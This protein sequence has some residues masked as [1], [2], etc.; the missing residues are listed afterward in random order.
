MSTYM[1]SATN[2][3]KPATTNWSRWLSATVQLISSIA[4]NLISHYICRY[5][6]KQSICCKRP[7]TIRW[8]INFRPKTNRWLKVFPL[9]WRIPA[10]LVKWF[11]II[12]TC[13]IWYCKGRGLASPMANGNPFWIGVCNL[14][15]TSMDGSSMTVHR[16]CWRCSN[17]KSIPRNGHR[18]TWIRIESQRSNRGR[19]QN[20]PPNQRRS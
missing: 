8:P 7:N 15:N 16:R 18:I 14:P 17:R 2:Y 1:K 20:R 11:S 9:H 19:I 13:P 10:C 3:W 6:V 5:W 12:R 4:S